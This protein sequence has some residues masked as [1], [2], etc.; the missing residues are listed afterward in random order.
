MSSTE[1]RN[2]VIA[3][4][5][6]CVSSLASPAEVRLSIV[7]I[8]GLNGEAFSTWQSDKMLW[9][10]HLIPKDFPH[11]RVFSIGYEAPVRSFPDPLF[12]DTIAENLLGTMTKAR[13][14]E[15]VPYRPIIWVAHSLGGLLLKAVYMSQS[16]P[17]CN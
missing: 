3:S 12:A 7:F 10:K 15:Q 17:L 14:A 13:H 9:P 11:A 1:A 2:H 16:Y 6:S 5:L 8:H 4:E